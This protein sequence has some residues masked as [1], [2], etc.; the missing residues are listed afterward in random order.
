MASTEMT[1]A[2]IQLDSDDLCDDY[3][4]KRSF[5]G[6]KTAYVVMCGLTIGP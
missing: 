6:H 2:H 4:L 3:D 1:V 5:K